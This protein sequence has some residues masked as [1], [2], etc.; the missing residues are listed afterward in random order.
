MEIQF[1]SEKWSGEDFY[2]IMRS[3]NKTHLKIHRQQIVASIRI[4]NIQSIQ[5]S[6]ICEV[7]VEIFVICAYRA[8]WDLG[9]VMRVEQKKK[10]EIVP[11]YIKLAQLDLPK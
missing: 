9:S 2:F 7:V 1:W 8:R 4:N 10:V 3:W 11:V 5:I 6:W